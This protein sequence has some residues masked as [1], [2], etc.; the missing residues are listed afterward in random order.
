MICAVAWGIEYLV[1]YIQARRRTAD[2]AQLPTQDAG[3]TSTTTTTG[4][5]D[6]KL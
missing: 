4:Q 5:H 6:V 2:A 3:V 1:E